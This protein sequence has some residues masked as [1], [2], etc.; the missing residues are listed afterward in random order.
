MEQKDR[1]PVVGNLVVRA[2]MMI[3]FS[4]R[5]RGLGPRLESLGL[6]LGLGG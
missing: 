3:V 4:F 1:Q 6:G 2:M 5:V